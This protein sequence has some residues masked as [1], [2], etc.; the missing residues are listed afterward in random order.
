MSLILKDPASVL[1]YSIDWRSSYLADDALLE[2][3]WSVVPVESGGVT[4]D[5][6]SHDPDAARVNVSGGRPGKLYRLINHVVTSLGRED[7]RSIIIR[8]EDR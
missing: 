4:I 1:D 3:G 5:G 6:S 8:V 7:S 2:S